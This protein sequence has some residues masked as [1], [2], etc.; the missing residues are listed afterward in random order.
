MLHIHAEVN[1]SLF[2]P[3]FVFAM[4]HAVILPHYFFKKNLLLVQCFQDMSHLLISSKAYLK[5]PFL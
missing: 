2:F 4:I 3:N 5:I 1:N